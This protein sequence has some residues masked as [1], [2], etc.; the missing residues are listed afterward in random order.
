MKPFTIIYVIETEVEG[1]WTPLGASL[2]KEASEKKC[3]ELKASNRFRKYE[4]SEY[5]LT[6]DFEYFDWI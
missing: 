1:R 6:D 3:K 2:S 5:A 4:V